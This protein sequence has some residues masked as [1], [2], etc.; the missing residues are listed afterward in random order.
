MDLSK[1][2]AI[3]G[4]GGL[5]RIISQSKGG[6]IVES[7]SD[8]KKIPVFA[9]HRS[10]ILEEISVYT[11]DDDVPLKDVLWRLHQH[12]NG[13][14]TSVN[15]KSGGNELSEYFSR[16]MPEYDRDRVYPSD[17]KKILG[18][19]NLLLEHDLISEPV[20]ET[21]ESTENK[22][23]DK[24]AEENKKDTKSEDNDN[25][26]TENK[27]APKKK[28]MEKQTKPTGTGKNDKK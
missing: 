5:F 3:S 10:S 14:K 24:P 9:T 4:R 20:D 15:L 26:A 17:I 21:D 25:S 2:L 23:E 27:P 18:W 16:V 1:I 11:E 19:Y 8:G 13:T 6:L 22:K 7:L 12:E 28:T